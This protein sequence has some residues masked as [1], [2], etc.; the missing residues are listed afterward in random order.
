VLLMIGVGKPL[1]LKP[2]PKNIWIFGP[3]SWALLAQTST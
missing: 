3:T 1:A 2:K